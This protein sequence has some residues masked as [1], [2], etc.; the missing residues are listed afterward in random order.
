LQMLHDWQGDRTPEKHEIA[1]AFPAGLPE[2]RL[3]QFCC[4]T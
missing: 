3:V 1:P 2:Q 4:G